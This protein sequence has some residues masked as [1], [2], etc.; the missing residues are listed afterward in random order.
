MSLFD[1]LVIPLND[2]CLF[3]FG[4]SVI[5]KTVGN[6]PFSL[7]CVQTE[8]ASIMADAFPSQYIVLWAKMADLPFGEVPAKGD[9]FTVGIK[10]YTV[11]VLKFEDVGG[12]FYFGA[13]LGA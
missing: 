7:N 1:T 6:F 4:D 3:V 11:V 8:K 13:D 2:D 5:Y 9:I 10:T 12:G